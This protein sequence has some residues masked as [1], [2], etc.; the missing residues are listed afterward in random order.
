MG[1]EISVTEF[2]AKCLELCEK[3]S[4]NE[5][6]SIEVT[7][8]GKPLVTVK[9][10]VNRVP[11]TREEALVALRRWQEGMKGT[12][13]VDP[14]CDLTQPASSI[15]DWDAYHGKVFPEDE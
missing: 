12:I 1:I 14:N 6:D 3:L 13:W 11:E 7:K 5:I 8:R 15:E 10:S 4:R 2:K 9:S